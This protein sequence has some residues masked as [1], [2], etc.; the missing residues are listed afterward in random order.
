MQ[1]ASRSLWVI[2]SIASTVSQFLQSAGLGDEKIEDSIL[3]L[4]DRLKGYR[5]R[6]K[7]LR[8]ETVTSS[9]AAMRRGQRGLSIRLM[10]ES[11]GY[12]GCAGRAGRFAG[13]GP[14]SPPRCA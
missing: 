9:V 1:D 12:I 4:I 10:G 8:P 11:L 14:N 3:C 7:A 2:D 5:E 6:A 13:E